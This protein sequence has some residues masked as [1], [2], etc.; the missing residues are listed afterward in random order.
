MVDRQAGP[1]VDRL[2]IASGEDRRDGLAKSTA[3]AYAA[4]AAS[5]HSL[6]YKIPTLLADEWDLGYLGRLGRLNGISDVT[7]MARLPFRMAIAVAPSV[8]ERWTSLILAALAGVSPWTMISEHG[9]L[10]L[11]RALSL[12]YAPTSHE[13]H[14]PHRHHRFAFLVTLASPGA[15]CC[16]VCVREDQEQLGT[17]YWRRSHQLPGQLW[18]NLHGMPLSQARQKHAFLGSPADALEDS[19]TASLDAIMS[20]GDHFRVASFMALQRS[21]LCQ[22]EPIPW[23]VAKDMAKLDRGLWQDSSAPRDFLLANAR[24]AYPC[25]WLNHVLLRQWPTSIRR[26]RR[27]NYCELKLLLLLRIA[28]ARQFGTDVVSPELQSQRLRFALPPAQ[29]DLFMPAGLFVQGEARSRPKIEPKCP[30]QRFSTAAL[31]RR[32]A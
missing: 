7:A 18:C 13:E 28:V 9:L 2:A 31:L 8:Q 27:T 19:D 11:E 32:Q 15:M 23:H 20:S 1:P 17:P 14:Q 24:A 12:D 5:T 16:R 10:P 26:R 30:S 6:A 21:M 3:A 25:A 4:I 22:K 29:R